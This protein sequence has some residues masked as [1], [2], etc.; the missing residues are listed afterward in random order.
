[1]L[2]KTSGSPGTHR[3]ERAHAEEDFAFGSLWSGS[4][5]TAA[6]LG[7][8]LPIAVRLFVVGW[9]LAAWLCGFVS[10]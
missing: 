7:S 9:R 10:L 2:G 1:M 3:T 4:E 8:P 6:L 5:R